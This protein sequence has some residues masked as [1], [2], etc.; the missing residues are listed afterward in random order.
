MYNYNYNKSTFCNLATAVL[1]GLTSATINIARNNHDAVLSSPVII[2][3][4]LSPSVCNQFLV[5]TVK[6]TRQ[7]EIIS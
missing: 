4:I 5:A 2:A 6:Y 7:N 1:F 3:N